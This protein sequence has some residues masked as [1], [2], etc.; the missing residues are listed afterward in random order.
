MAIGLENFYADKAVTVRD[1]VRCSVDFN[2][3]ESSHDHAS[4]DQ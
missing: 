2:K 3:E 1:G 4:R